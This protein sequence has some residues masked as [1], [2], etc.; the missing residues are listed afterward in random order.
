MRVEE[1]IYWRGNSLWIHYSFRGQTFRESAHT[2]NV[3][4]ARKLRKQRLKQVERPGFIG[5]KEEKWTLADMKEKI[6][7]DYERKQNRSFDDVENAFKHL[8]AEDAFKFHRVVDI[9]SEKIA[10]YG[11]KRLKAGA[12]RASVNYELATLRRGFKLMSE[13]GMISTVPVIK[14]YAVDNARQGFI[15]VADFNA[16]LEK[17]LENRRIRPDVRDIIEFLY[18]AGWRSIEAEAFEWSWIDRNMIRVP[19]EI[20]KNKKDRAFPIIGTLIDILERR[21]KLRRLDCPYVFHRNGKPIRSFRKAFKAAAKEV[22]YDGLLPHD[23]RRSAIRNFRKAG[24]SE[25]DGMKLSG[26]RTRSVYDRYNIFDD[27]DLAES[28]N[29][30]QE[31]LKKEAENRKVVPLKRETA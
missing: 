19:K 7:L 14:L 5:P 10:E 12:A 3:V 28:M 25:S 27:R 22:G 1:G 29:R 8:E 2:D 24:L 15:D 30:V 26:H 21:Q 16:L 31:H 18:H 11:D 20:A 6:R 9:T 4:V 13:A 23:M 17:I